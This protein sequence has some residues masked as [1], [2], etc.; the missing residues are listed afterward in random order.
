LANRARGSQNRELAA[1]QFDPRLVTALDAPSPEET[2]VFY[3]A[4]VEAT[5]Q[6]AVAALT[7]DYFREQRGDYVRVL[8]GR[9]CEELTIAQVAE[10]LQ[11]TPATVDNYFRHA[12]QRLGDQLERLVRQHVACHIS[13]D[14]VEEVCPRVAVL[15]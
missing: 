4:W 3:V 10:R 7:L 12:R 8:F 14:E 2:D 1:A 5:V 15:R 11:V 6:R 13:A 9:I